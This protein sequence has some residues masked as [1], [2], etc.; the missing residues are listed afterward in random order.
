VVKRPYNVPPD[1][2]TRYTPF[3]QSYPTA[4]PRV[5]AAQT[6]N[7]GETRDIWAS[8]RDGQ[9][10]A[11]Q[12]TAATDDASFMENPGPVAGQADSVSEGEIE[13]F[14]GKNCSGEKYSLRLANEQN[15][16]TLM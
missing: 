11:R 15:L 4:D 3:F 2:T 9:N 5:A 16:T 8:A 1:D 6:A 7:V 12:R 14:T 10:A 13:S